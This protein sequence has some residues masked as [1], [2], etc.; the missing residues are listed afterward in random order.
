M[1]QKSL[2]F[3]KRLLHVYGRLLSLLTVAQLD[4]VIICCICL[5]GDENCGTIKKRC[6]SSRKK[7]DFKLAR[8]HGYTVAA[9]LL[10]LQ[11]KETLQFLF[12]LLDLKV[13][14]AIESSLVPDPYP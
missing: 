11:K 8:C 6:W 10:L 3:I 14:T 1:T 9:I 12:I 5:S 7:Y 2:T 13:V 4:S